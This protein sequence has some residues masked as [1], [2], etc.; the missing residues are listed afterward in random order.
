MDDETDQDAKRKPDA[1]NKPVIPP[2]DLSRRPPP[3]LSPLDQLPKSSPADSPSGVPPVKVSIRPEGVS[4][5]DADVSGI[6]SFNSRVV[7]AVIDVL[8]ATGITIGL[9]WFLP[10]FADR[11]AQLAGIAYFVTRDSLPFMGGQ[12]AGKK[13]MRLRATTLEGDSL[14]KNWQAAVI[15]NG[16]LL[17]PLFALVELYVLLSRDGAA[18]RGRRLGD[19]WAKTQVIV[20]PE[21]EKSDGDTALP[22]E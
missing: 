12:S 10:D 4:S 11:L 5:E 17:I 20:E 6:A 9:S 13:A 8:V 22:P 1:A 18:N 3:P 15:R 19:E 16:I 14:V 21:P 7:A 2:P